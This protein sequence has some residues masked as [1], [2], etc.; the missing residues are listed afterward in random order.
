MVGISSER[1]VVLISSLYLCSIVYCVSMLH[2]GLL[3]K[4][5]IILLE[6]PSKIEYNFVFEDE[7]LN[8]FMNIR[9]VDGQFYLQFSLGFVKSVTL[10][11]THRGR[12]RKTMAIS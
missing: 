1:S 6:K 10:L 4:S 3:S 11:E 12:L 7:I 5:E 2:L 9:G 8:V